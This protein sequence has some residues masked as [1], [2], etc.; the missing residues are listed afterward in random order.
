M[1]ILA[2]RIGPAL[3][4]TN[5]NC[6]GMLIYL[7]HSPCVPPGSG[8]RLLYSHRAWEPQPHSPRRTCHNS[9]ESP[10]ASP[11]AAMAAGLAM[12]NATH[13]PRSTITSARLPFCSPRAP[14]TS[15]TACV[16]RVKI[17]ISRQ[18]RSIPVA[19]YAI[20]RC[21]L[22][23]PARPAGSPLPPMAAR[24]F[25]ARAATAPPGIGSAPIPG[26]IIP[27]RIGSRAG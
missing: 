12:I 25:R 14:L 9:Q 18:R 22:S 16:C 21:P 26:R 7:C 20:P 17:P 8:L 3:H 4:P 15:W 27:P 24:G 11:P 2:K 6:Q 1:I 19:R 13:G 23:R 10:P 5:S